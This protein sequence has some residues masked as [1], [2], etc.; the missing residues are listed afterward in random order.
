MTKQV[1]N[2]AGMTYHF[3]KYSFNSES[4]YM[5]GRRDARKIADLTRQGRSSADIARNYKRQIKEK[6][7]TFESIVG[8]DFV[9][10]LDQ[11]LFLEP[12][13]SARHQALTQIQ[14]AQVTAFRD[15]EGDDEELFRSHYVRKR[16]GLSS[17]K[18]TAIKA[19][20]IAAFTISFLVVAYALVTQVLNDIS[21]KQQRNELA[22]I[23][24]AQ[25]AATKD[26]VMATDPVL[27][28]TQ[29]TEETN[30]ASTATRAIM[31]QYEVLHER[32]NDLAGWL[33]IPDTRVDYPVMFL[34]GDNDF[35]LS[36]NFD[37]QYDI[38]GLLVLDKRCNADATGTNILIHGHNMD[39]GD[40]FGE[41]DLYN[42]YDYYAAHPQ[43]YFNSLYEKRVYDIMAVFVSSVFNSNADDFAYYDYIQIDNEEDYNTYVQTAKEQ[44]LYDT[45]ITATY[46]D[47]LITLST[48][49]YTHVN[50]RLVIVGRRRNQ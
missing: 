6:K 38:N 14:S 12:A 7:L 36:H 22:Q 11:T 8:E 1:K 9:A 31:P 37:K 27:D 48:C 13:G 18:M 24:N 2:T 40:I 50:G 41:L 39:N 3:G 45:G 21:G 26:V 32:N 35:Y 30:E 5:A 44:S 33:K 17:S 19:G 23:A 15:D 43:I 47:E 49:E 4:A 16:R 29:S 46:G 42:S 25:A 28:V 20:T 10:G 34:E